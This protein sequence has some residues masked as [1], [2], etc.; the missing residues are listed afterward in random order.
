M[1]WI[2]QSDDVSGFYGVNV[3]AKVRNKTRETEHV[4]FEHGDGR[5]GNTKESI[6]CWFPDE[7]VAANMRNPT[8][9]TIDFDITL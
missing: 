8:R 2:D 9:M 1:D 6:W 7:H 4:R 5:R 3:V